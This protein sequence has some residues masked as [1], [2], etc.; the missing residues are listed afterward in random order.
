MMKNLIAGRGDFLPALIGAV[1]LFYSVPSSVMILVAPDRN[2]SILGI[3]LLII[4]GLGIV[5]GCIFIVVSVRLCS[6]PGSRI[7]RISHGRFF[8]P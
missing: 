8:G 4:F 3:P 5:L 7:Y 1:I 2:S 6:T